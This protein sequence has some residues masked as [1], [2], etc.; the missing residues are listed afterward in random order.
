MTLVSTVAQRLFWAWAVRLGVAVFAAWWMHTRGLW[1]ALVQGDPSGISVA[2]TVL[3]LF[4]TLWCGRHAW[5]LQNEAAD[6]SDWR[7]TYAQARAQ[8]PGWSASSPTSGSA[9]SCCC[10]T[11]RPIASSPTSWRADADETAPCSLRSLP[12]WGVSVS[13]GVGTAE[14]KTGPKGFSWLRPGSDEQAV[15]IRDL[16]VPQLPEK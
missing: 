9:S 1:R 7:H 3:S 6:G 16:P 10:S 14:P 12:P 15:K 11:A 4:V 5:R 2:I 13:S 8:S